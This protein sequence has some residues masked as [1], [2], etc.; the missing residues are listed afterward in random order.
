M[1]EK[2]IYISQHERLGERFWTDENLEKELPGI[3]RHLKE[4]SRKTKAPEYMYLWAE[5]TFYFNSGLFFVPQGIRKSCLSGRDI[6]DCGASH[7]DSAL[8]FGRIQGVRKVFSFEPVASNFKQ[9]LDTIAFC[10]L[11]NVMPFKLGVGERK[12]VARM[13][14]EGFSSSIDDAARGEKVEVTDIDS[15]VREHKASLGVVKLDVEGHE[16]KAIKGAMKSIIRDRP[17]LLI[18]IYHT[19]EDFF[20]IK[21]Y[22]EGRLKGYRYMIRHLVHYH[23]VYETVLIGYPEREVQHGKRRKSSW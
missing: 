7:G 10:G 4:F 9:L 8:A 22:L 14:D 15:F 17:I 3:Y 16:L 12:A 19:P 2:Y 21:P 5:D 1:L 20:K 6:L 11:D 13:D 23:P 18:S